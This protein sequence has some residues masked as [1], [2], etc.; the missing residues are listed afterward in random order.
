MIASNAFCENAA[1][2]YDDRAL[3]YQPHPE[4]LTPYLTGLLEV[5]APGVVPAPLIQTA[6][7]D[8]E[9]PVATQ[10]FADR[11]AA[12]FKHPRTSNG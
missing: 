7:S 9:K 6:F 3:P 10:A 1:L 11:I 8:I 5:R 12:F 4:F 2:V